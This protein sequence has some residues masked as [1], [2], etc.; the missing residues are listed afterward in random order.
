MKVDGGE[1]KY[2][3]RNATMNDRTGNRY[4]MLLGALL[5]FGGVF[6]F[7]VEGRLRSVRVP[8]R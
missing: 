6:G 1:R 2:A 3:L 7:I 5:T 8:K 4:L